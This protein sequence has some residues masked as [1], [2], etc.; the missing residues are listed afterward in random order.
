MKGAAKR[1]V[2]STPA[3]SSVS[4]NKRTKTIQFE[5]PGTPSVRTMI[6][7]ASS[8]AE[9]A[10]DNENSH[11]TFRTLPKRHLPD[12]KS[13]ASI[14]QGTPSVH[15]IARRTKKCPQAMPVLHVLVP[16]LA[17]QDMLAGDEDVHSLQHQ[18]CDFCPDTVLIC[19][20]SPQFKA[21]RSSHF[22]KT[23]RTSSLGLYTA[24]VW[25]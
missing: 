9:V 20:V 1:I 21:I 6:L 11:C 2:D 24:Q 22:I 13:Y 15:S 4:T 23:T 17:T 12:I 19:A 3:K 8:K 16:F 7:P 10:F 14:S 5:S 18:E 25:S